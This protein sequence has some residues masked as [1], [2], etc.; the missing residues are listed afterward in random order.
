VSDIE[1]LTQGFAWYMHKKKQFRNFCI[2]CEEPGLTKEH[3]WADWLRNHIPRTRQHVRHTASLS[4]GNPDEKSLRVETRKGKI[5]GPGDPHSR[6]LKVLCKDCNNV[7]GS[8]LQD[9]IKPI[10]IPLLNGDTSGL[11]ER[12][13]PLLSAWIAL[14][15][16][17]AE[18]S[19]PPTSAITQTQRTYLRE[20]RTAPH[21]FH[22]WIG[23]HDG[24]EQMVGA[25]NHFGLTYGPTFVGYAGPIRP[26]TFPSQST[27]FTVGK[28]FCLC[29][30]SDRQTPPP[31]ASEI[32]RYPMIK[33]WP[34]EQGC[35]LRT[36]RDMT[37][38]EC[39][40]I[41]RIFVPPLQWGDARPI[42]G[43]R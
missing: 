16:A 30:S 39:D 7:W 35:V 24:S 36:A 37:A 38:S 2:L 34:Q 28:L 19:D 14:F 10:L 6:K 29:F 40:H 5:D 32:K 21:D 8:G 4:F 22:I 42:S 43:I 31:W 41:S 3:I 23:F 1:T 9:D 13:T 20:E 27:A 18:Y 12:E 33:I 15:V 11:N 17:V 25:Y 26:N